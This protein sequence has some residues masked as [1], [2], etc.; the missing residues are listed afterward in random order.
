[1]DIANDFMAS[2][3]SRINP[4][5]NLAATHAPDWAGLHARLTAAHAAAGE[6]LR[7]AGAVPIGS[8]VEWQSSAACNPSRAVN[9]NVLAD[10]KAEIGNQGGAA[11][12]TRTGGRGQS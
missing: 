9:P 6:L 11:G 2:L 10:G 12:A 3:R 4:G 1:M 5:A 8:F 7:K